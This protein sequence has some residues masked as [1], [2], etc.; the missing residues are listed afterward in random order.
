MV[1]GIKE[2]L[3]DVDGKLKTI[4]NTNGHR[5][6]IIEI[7]HK[8]L[9]L[10]ARLYDEAGTDPLEARLPAL[11]ARQ[12][13][14]VLEKF[15]AQPRRLG[16]LQGQYLSLE[17]WHE[18]N[19]QKDGTIKRDTRFPESPQQWILSGP[20]FF[21]GNP[22]YKTAKADCKTHLDYASPDLQTL[23]DDYLP[24]TNYIP[25]CDPDTYRARTPRVPWVE[26]GES[27]PRLVT[28]YYRLIARAM[29]S[30]SGERTLITALAPKQTGHMNG[31]RTYVYKNEGFLIDH[32]AM[33]GSI[34]FDFMCKSTGKANLHQMLDDFTYVDFGSLSSAVRSRE[35]ALSCITNHYADL[36]QSNW[37]DS[38]RRQQWACADTVP[39]SALPRDFFA[40]LT[41]HWQRH[42]ALRS[43]Y[44]RRQALVEID[45][46]VAQAL[47]LT[48]EELLTIYRVQFPVMRQYEAETFYDQNGRIVFTPSKGLTGVGLPRKASKKELKEGTRYSLH[49]PTQTT[50][51]VALGWE[52]IRHLQEGTVTKTFIDDTLPGGPV[53]RTVEYK[54]PFFKPDREE[55]YRVA[56]EVFGSLEL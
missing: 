40:R 44:A 41:P 2:E 56:W 15:A 23:P 16:D 30:Q 13:I 33:T 49:T 29:L 46:L 36:W 39:D 43:D 34:P 47:G 35:L 7:G 6:R 24:R 8:E 50:Q 17:M 32:V 9:A 55:D 51:D 22:F 25:A 37:H 45:V 42:N 12:L 26:E 27:G 54:A 31:A 20:H 5:D 4:W 28:E 53:E 14:S 52:D 18:T 3:I 19:A 38:F 21:V 48:L 1:L 11:H 10:F